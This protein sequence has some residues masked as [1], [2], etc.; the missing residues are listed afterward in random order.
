VL[1]I[2]VEKFDIHPT[3]A[4]ETDMAAMLS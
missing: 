1:N 3:H 4:V 2:L